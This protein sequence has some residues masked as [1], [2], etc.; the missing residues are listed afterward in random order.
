MAHYD[1]VMAQSEIASSPLAEALA[2]VDTTGER[3][4]EAELYR[5][6]GELLL[7]QARPDVLQAERCFQKAL[8]IVRRRQAKSWELRA[9]VSLSR[10]WQRQGR[11]TAAYKVL[12]EV[13]NRFTEGLD[14][15]DLLAAKAL[16]DTATAEP[17]PAGLSPTGTGLGTQDTQQLG[18]EDIGV[19]LPLQDKTLGPLRAS[20]PRR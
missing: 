7:Q 20:G 16:R 12:A 4:Y 15:A 5:L 19:R 9:A 18:R 2:R 10:L 13:Y 8:A 3:V 11:L 17:D 1:C 6:K 14:T